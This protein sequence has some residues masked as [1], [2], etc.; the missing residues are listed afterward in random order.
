MSQSSSNQQSKREEMQDWLRFIRGESHI[1]RERPWLLF[2]QAPNHPDSK[3][4]A[5]AANTR[6]EAGREGKPWL[7]CFATNTVADGK[8][9]AV[10]SSRVCDRPVRLNPF[11]IDETAPAKWWWKLWH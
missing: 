2:Q 7:F 6:A 8:L 10:V 11:V 3:A 5:Q 9:N 4:P 1:L